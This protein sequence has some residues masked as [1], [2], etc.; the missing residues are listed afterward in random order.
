MREMKHPK[1]MFES[2]R[3]GRAGRAARA[4]NAASVRPS[5]PRVVILTVTLLA[6]CAPHVAEDFRYG[7]F[8]RRGIPLPIPI[9]A[10]GCV[11]MMQL[12]GSLLALRRSPAG[13]A[14]LVG[15]GLVW[16][17]GA[18]S[19]HGSEILSAAPYRSGVLSKALEI[20]IVALGAATAIVG[21]FEWPRRRR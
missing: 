14:L 1:S 19:V 3:H 21:I 17:V 11:V 12:A 7:E 2:G 6:V 16:C 15:A 4:Q 8:A 18:M 5:L 10:L 20:A 9:A 13:F